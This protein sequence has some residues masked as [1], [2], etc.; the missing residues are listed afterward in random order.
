[1][2]LDLAALA[3]AIALIVLVQLLR[4]I[5]A[6]PFP[7]IAARWLGT[8]P[9]K[10]FADWI[11]ELE[12]Q[13]ATLGFEAA[14]WVR[15]SR[16][17]G[18]ADTLP[19]RA[20][21]R[22]ASGHGTAWVGTPL[23]ARQPHR[24]TLFFADLLAD[25]RT[26]V[27]QPFDVYFAA[28]QG[29]EIV[30]RTAAE[31]TLAAQWQAHRAWIESLGGS[32]ADRSGDDAPQQHAAL[33]ERHRQWLLQHRQ[34][35]AVTADLALPRVGFALALLRAFLKTP[36]LPID[37][38]PVS[39]ERLA[40][41]ARVQETVR[42][43]APP[44]RVQWGLF[45]FSVALFMLAGAAIWNVEIALAILV[46][47]LIHELGHFLAM[48]AFGYRNVHMLALPLVG[49]VAIGEDAEPAA[50][51]RAWMSLMGPLPGIVIGWALLLV[52]MFGGLDWTDG[53]LFP[54]ALVF[55]FINYLNV[56]PVPPL[57]GAH[58][59]ESLLPLRWARV[60]TVF[61]GVAA[62]LGAWLAWQFDFVLLT[63]LALLQLPALP[64][65]WR[66]HGV[67]RE[68]A[69]DPELCRL[70][71]N[72]RLL[73]VLRRM[74]FA[75]G[76]VTDASTRIQL[77]LRV[78]LRLDNR[79]MGHVS[80]ALI[81]LVYISLLI[82]PVAGLVVYS[83]SDIGSDI[84]SAERWTAEQERFAAEAHSLDL[85][86]L[87]DAL[88]EGAGSARLPP[89]S[90]AAI[91]AAGARLGHSLPNELRA[92]YALTDGLPAFGLRPVAEL[93]RAA[94]TGIDALLL[95]APSLL[96]DRGDGTQVEI[97]RATLG[98]WWDIGGDAEYRLLYLPVDEPRLPGVRLL[99]L[100][101]GFAVTRT[102]LRT[103]L[104]GQW[105][106][107]R[108][109]Q[110]RAARFDAVRERIEA[111]W[112][113]KPVDA[114]IDAWQPRDLLVS[115][116]A[117]DVAWGDAADQQAFDAAAQRLGAP[118]PDELR[119]VLARHDG[120]PPLQLLPS[121]EVAEWRDVAAEVNQEWLA[122]MAQ[123]TDDP[124]AVAIDDAAISDCRLVAGLRFADADGQ[125]NTLPRLL[126]CPQHAKPWLDIGERRRYASLR[127]WIAPQAI[128]AA[129]R[130]A[131][132]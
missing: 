4:T 49:G 115:L 6:L 87:V 104:A 95:D 61:V 66:L 121:A 43:R 110:A 33:I 18:G 14:R 5:L 25:G 10:V 8:P 34:L 40:L 31:P 97:D 78:Q 88:S 26:A 112:A 101:Y 50:A 96:V 107:L 9:P 108:A 16:V 94:D 93:A 39:A 30:G 91:A 47:V 80:R 52:S 60:Q 62:L 103:A 38:R 122:M 59:V 57:D 51:R 92:V 120:F 124:D 126:W 12:P 129:A 86:A 68:L 125:R 64:T 28:T 7:R 23:N 99:Q 105:A 70:H 15:V 58:V 54:L 42:H 76:P 82:V 75:L 32:A 13:L 21:F 69:A 111:E 37:K 100:D 119:A 2:L 35:R 41:L 19:L 114:L 85:A 73:R 3:A 45:G 118:L 53:W 132:L 72:A 1:M 102:D 56:L 128:Q 123:A 106:T 17:D 74:N 55:L 36:K 67:E 84:A 130:E 90:E 131:S 71:R 98:Q 22:H 46:V 117:G 11:A 79:P 29:G 65:Q 77:A 113:D 127:A 44:K 116:L 24:H 48:R 109:G 20:M 89:A 81:S 27:S 63:A 83:S